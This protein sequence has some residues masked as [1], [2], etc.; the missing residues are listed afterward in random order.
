MRFGRFLRALS[1]LALVAG[2]RNP[3]GAQQPQPAVLAGIV[4]DEY[5]DPLAGAEV[6]V[7][8]G[9]RTSRTD[10]S[11]GFRI[12]SK[13]GEYTAIFRRLGYAPED[14]SWL[15]RAGQTTNL[16]IRLDPLPHG[17]DPIVVRDNHDRVAG[18]STI[19]G[20]VLDSAFQ[21]IPGVEL[22]LIGTGRHAV[23][24]EDGTF[25]V[26]G[27]A[28]GNYV[29]RARRMGFSP[30]NLTVKVGSGE[31]HDVALKLAQLPN[32]LATV[33]V[34]ERSGFG[35]SAAAWEEFD[36]RQRWK[37]GLTGTVG[38]DELAAKGR[39][40][41]DLALRSSSAASLLIIPTWFGGGGHTS[42]VS[43]AV[44]P[45]SS[46]SVEGDQCVL[47]N[48]LI[49]ERRPLSSFDARDV[50]RV[51]IFPANTDWTATIGARMHAVPGCESPDDL[52]HPPYFV[53]WMRGGS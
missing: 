19:A 38:R 52:H 41:L 3:L 18:A 14:F 42:I 6:R 28:A 45:S 50:E 46:P 22:Q 2:L 21:P 36:R 29:I 39:M 26:A 23:T 15:A 33:E 7:D 24:Y 17:L 12:E 5:G 47:I 44:T 32:T 25:F 31:R 16:S 10:S 51:E 43:G 40:P 34:T 4:K 20:V 11:G 30:V 53:V 13:S 48:G 37:L 9:G 1:L 49:G 35:Q 8:P 27:L